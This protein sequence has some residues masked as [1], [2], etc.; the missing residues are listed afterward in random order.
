[1]LLQLLSWRPTLMLRNFGHIVLLIFTGSLLLFQSCSTEK[2]APVNVGYHNM[3]ARYNGYFN[4]RMI[5]Q[6]SLEGYRNGAVE[7][8]THL[9]PL[10]L[11]PTQE[12]VSKIQDKYETAQ[13]KCEKVIHRHSMPNSQTRNKNEEN[14]RWIDDNWFV[15]GQIN[16]TRREYSK[17]VEIFKFIVESPLYV[18]QER[19]HEARIWLA[20]TYIA[21]GKFPE[22]K[23]I[24]AQVEI[25]MESA[26]SESGK[27]KDKVKLSGYQKK[28]LKQQK[29][30]DK[31]NN[32]MS[33]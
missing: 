22:A 1:M 17:A 25:D 14:C 10:D 12:D 9:L 33:N 28:K 20:K 8:Y 11:Y 27:G 19:V 21:M 4:A 18:D 6:E 2:D 32:R 30:K 29:K 7:D 24:L 16:Y 3:T 31:K 26:E 15:L 13:E 23:R 5:I